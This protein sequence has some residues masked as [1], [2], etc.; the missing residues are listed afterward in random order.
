MKLEQSESE[1]NKRKLT[2]NY[3]KEESQKKP[4]IDEKPTIKAKE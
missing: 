2:D 3:M 4:T 1:L